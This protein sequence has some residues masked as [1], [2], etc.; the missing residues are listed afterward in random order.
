M[1]ELELIKVSHECK[2]G[3][4]PQE[5]SPSFSGDA[6]FI[7]GGEQVGFYLSR[8]PERLK[9]LTDVA[10]CELNSERVPKTVMA[11]AS[12]FK[13]KALAVDQYSCIIG[14]IP[15]K[16]IMRRPYPS[17]SSVHGVNS[18]Q[19]FIK[20][21][22]MAGREALKIIEETTPDLYRSHKQAVQ[23][24]VPEKWRFCDLFTSSISNYNIA[25]PIHRDT[26]NVKGALNVIITKRLNSTGGN[27]FIPDYNITINSAHDS[28]LVYPAWRNTHGVTP[29]KATHDGGYRNSLI[30]Y[31]L[32]AFGKY[33]G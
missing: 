27:L 30:W 2:I 7:S 32:D 15:P 1:K 19:I 13:D 29:I 33:D 18:A 3:Q 20:A 28:M 25:A 10:N 31:A 26:L 8:I 24:R 12:K 14:S 4:K 5:L 17:R 23:Q 6:L 9:K 16:A 22:T 21:M 11:R